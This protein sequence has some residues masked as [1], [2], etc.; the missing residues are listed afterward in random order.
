MT[1]P[2]LTP[3]RRRMR[4]ACGS[5][6]WPASTR[7]WISSAQETALTALPNSA[8]R[9]SPTLPNTRPSNSRTSS[10]KVSRRDLSAASV[11]ASSAPISRLYATTSAARMAAILRLSRG[12]APPPGCPPKVYPRRAGRA[13]TRLRRGCVRPSGRP[14]CRGS[15]G[16]GGRG[17]PGPS[18]G[19]RTGWWTGRPARSRR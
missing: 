1:S 3:M 9:L 19:L 5:D 6:A 8:I 12:T 18:P 10:S 7:R 17:A 14:S 4:A 15:P 16:S 2:R 13:L 11:P